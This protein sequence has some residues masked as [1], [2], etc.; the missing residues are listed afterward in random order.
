MPRRDLW[1]L[2]VNDKIGSGPMIKLYIKHPLYS[3]V[4]FMPSDVPTVGPNQSF[5]CLSAFVSACPLLGLSLSWNGVSPP[6]AGLAG[7]PT[8]IYGHHLCCAIN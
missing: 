2:P 1:R 4:L 3:V 5:L 8:D 7:G 6:Y